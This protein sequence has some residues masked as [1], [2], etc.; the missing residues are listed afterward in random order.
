MVNDISSEVFGYP[1]T[2]YTPPMEALGKIEVIRGAASLQYCNHSLVDYSI[3][4]L[5][6]EIRENLYL[7]KRNK[8]SAFT[9][10]SIPTMQLVER[11]KNF[12]ITDSCIIV[13]PKVGATIVVTIYIQRIFLQAIS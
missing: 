4:K 9:V 10:Y 13:L 3:I 12:P 7:L 5:K 8:L 2:Y 1:E 6:K 11:I